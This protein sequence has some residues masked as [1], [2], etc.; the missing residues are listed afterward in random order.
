M[1]CERTNAGGVSKIPPKLPQ[2]P[3]PISFVRLLMQCLK[4]FHESTPKSLA[5][6]TVPC[7]THNC[8]THLPPPCACLGK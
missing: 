3:L 7:A 5:T 1:V 8:T 2:S 4:L 6:V